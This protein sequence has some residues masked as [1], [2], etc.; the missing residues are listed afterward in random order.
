MLALSA[1]ASVPDSGVRPAL[2]SAQTVAASQT[3][4]PRGPDIWPPD[5]WWERVDDPQLTALIEE[6]LTNAPQVAIAA[7]RI[8]RA[9]AEAQ[10][11]GAARYPSVSAEAE[12]GLLRQSRSFGIPAESLPGGWIDYGQAALNIGHDLDLWGRNRAAFAAATSERR[13]STPRRRGWC[14][15]S[16]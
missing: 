8:R 5:R 14:C 15:R 3:L 16:R 6:G 2:L 12:G 13:P 11:I 7:A 1:C 4:A 9:E 10:R